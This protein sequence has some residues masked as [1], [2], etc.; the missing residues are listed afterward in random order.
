MYNPEGGDRGEHFG[1]DM[2][3]RWGWGSQGRHPTLPLVFSRGG[4]SSVGLE[5]LSS[6]DPWVCTANSRAPRSS[7]RAAWVLPRAREQLGRLCTGLSLSENRS[8]P[9]LG[10]SSRTRVPGPTA[11]TGPLCRSCQP[12][13]EASSGPGQEASGSGQGPSYPRT[14]RL[15]AAALRLC[16][17]VRPSVWGCL[18][19]E[20]RVRLSVNGDAPL[21]VGNQ[22]GGE[23]P[24]SRVCGSEHP[25]I[26]QCAEPPESLA[27]LTG[28][29]GSLSWL[30]WHSLVSQPNKETANRSESQKEEDTSS[31]SSS[32]RLC[33]FL[34]IEENTSFKQRDG[35][36]EA[37][38][39]FSTFRSE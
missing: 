30:P 9:E 14:N 19:K 4:H 7:V 23:S 29:G 12:A 31:G 37:W 39:R 28:L 35:G 6:G 26:A 11:G 32:T 17:S 3:R 34:G 22:T 36:W 10:R 18:E 16:P 38:V 2:S 8:C 27:F 13:G 25:Q 15:A 33:H 20:S 21:Q 1:Y 24:I 5:G